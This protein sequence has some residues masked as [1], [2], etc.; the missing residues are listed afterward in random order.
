MALTDHHASQ[1][2]C[3]ACDIG[4][5]TRNHYFTG[6]L[7]LERDFTAEQQYVI[8]KLRHHHQRLHGWGRGAFGAE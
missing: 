2:L 5:F 4:P 8:D 3:H 6:K 1:T 7:L